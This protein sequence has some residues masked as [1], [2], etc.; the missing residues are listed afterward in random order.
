MRGLARPYAAR[1]YRAA[2][3][4][5]IYHKVTISVDKRHRFNLLAIKWEKSA[6]GPD[7]TTG[8]CRHYDATSFAC[9]DLAARPVRFLGRD[10]R[11][12]SRHG[13]RGTD[14]TRTSAPLDEEVTLHLV[15]ATGADRWALVAAARVGDDAGP[16]RVLVYAINVSAEHLGHQGR[17]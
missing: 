16:E 11:R 12:R 1:K 15:S 14:D 7:G 4:R 13:G 6:H 5:E 17:G 2:D 10:S 3:R 8:G 9:V